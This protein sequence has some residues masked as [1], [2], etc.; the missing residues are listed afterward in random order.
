MKQLDLFTDTRLTDEYDAAQERGEVASQGRPQKR[1]Q[2]GTFFSGHE[3]EDR[4]RE[5]NETL[6]GLSPSAPATLAEM[7]GFFKKE[8]HE[9]RQFRDAEVIRFPVRAWAPQIWRP[10]VV[11]IIK[12]MQA[13]KSDKG[14]TAFWK[15]E[16]I[17]IETQLRAGGASE[18]EITSE[19]YRFRQA[20]IAEMAR[21]GLVGRKG[22][23]AA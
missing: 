3:R 23:G 16:V 18:D 22:P 17:A 6:G 13:R 8:I 11:P 1:F 9:A 21:L 2:E 12:G 5:A 20:V 7:P 15:K 4:R 14:R 19:V 10:V